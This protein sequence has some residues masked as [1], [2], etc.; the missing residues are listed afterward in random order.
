MSQ[1]NT[2]V[3]TGY[4]TNSHQETAH[5][6]RLAGADRA[7]V[8]HFSDIVAAKVRLSEYQFLVF[9]GGFLDG[10]DLGAA[11]AAAQRWLHLSD[12]EGQPLLDSLNR[13]VDAGG[14]VLGICSSSSAYSPRWRGRV[15]SGRFPSAITTPPAMRTDGSSS[16]RTPTARVFSPK[17]WLSTVCCRCLS[18][19]AKAS[20][21]PA[22]PR[23]CSGCR[24]KT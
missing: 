8:V 18:V 16:S 9:P 21:W 15:L 22:M 12:A 6:A 20:S 5:A 11:Q 1:V 2:L 7:D 10:D 13:F 4:G 23:P 24:T 3:I 19:M 17:D 14:L